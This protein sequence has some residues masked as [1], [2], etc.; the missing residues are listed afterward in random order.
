MPEDQID[1]LP[2][3]LGDAQALADWL[4]AARERCIDTARADARSGLSAA[5]ALS[6]AADKLTAAAAGELLP[7][8]GGWVLLVLGEW[9]GGQLSPESP[10]RAAL[11][12]PESE[13]GEL[14]GMAMRLFALLGP[15][16]ITGEV[17]ALEKVVARLGSERRAVAELLPSRPI[18]GTGE[19]VS[20][21]QQKLSSAVKACGRQL[22]DDAVAALLKRHEAEGGSVCRLEPD[23]VRNP[24][25]SADF[26][27]VHWIEDVL[28]VAGL[29]EYRSGRGLLEEEDFEDLRAA[30]SFLSGCRIVLHGLAGEA[31]ERLDRSHQ[32]RLAAALA[33][34]SGEE[35]DAAGLLMRDVLREMR[36]VYRIVKVV[37]AQYEETRG[38]GSK[39]KAVDRRRP[40]GTD[41]IRIGKRIYLSRPDL[42][43]GRGAG[44][45]M[46]RGF[47]KA[48]GARLE[49]SQEF[50]KRV[51]DNL[52]MVGD[53]VRESEEAARLFREIL[54]VRGA[55]ADVLR[56]MHESGFL[57]AYLPEF[58]EVDCLVTGESNQE[59]T[60]DEH[61]LM[62]V[63]TLEQA[64][65]AGLPGFQ[66]S[67]E[68]AAGLPMDLLKLAALVHAI[69]KSRG[70]SGFASRSAVMVPRIARQ[71]RLDEREARML[72][73][74][75]EH[76]ML[77]EDVAG[78]RMTTDE[79]LLSELV[80]TIGE[81]E[82][83]DGLY[84][85][86][87]ADLAAL[88]PSGAPTLR[89]EQ[90]AALY[91]RLSAR[92]A[93]RPARSRGRLAEEVTALLGDVASLEE[94]EAHLEQ[95]PE[96]YLLEV[97][98]RDCLLHLELLREVVAGRVAVD[99]SRRK[100][101]VHVWVLG[102]DRPRRISQI[103]GAVLCAGASIVSARAYTRSDGI[104]I[105]QFDLVP[106]GDSADEGPDAFW[107][108]AAETIRE[109]LTSEDELGGRSRLA[110]LL[111]GALAAASSE[112]RVPGSGLKDQEA[113]IQAP[114][115][116]SGT[117]NSEPRVSFDNLI[118]A[119]Y[120]VLDV[121][122]PDRPGL[123]YALS[124]G[125]AD[126]GADIAFAKINTIGGV[127][128]DVFYVTIGDAKVAGREDQRRIRSAINAELRKLI[129]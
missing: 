5:G 12:A 43:E 105:D 129:G 82:Y 14:T 73:F 7:A 128:Q 30:S 25:G 8:G 65:V 70:A 18:G 34:R 60:V 17:W 107:G 63:A 24:G 23:L 62:T 29:V 104:I 109:V 89:G 32:V 112:F 118:S 66:Q 67:T 76:Q 13:I 95:V 69:G 36:A 47:H 101:H 117:Q 64:E 59:Y 42:F 58:S 75:T 111:E 96:R 71:L 98:P 124:A 51:S 27:A 41:F 19:A 22:V 93:A 119:D 108:S 57:G 38:W 114:N 10:M 74:L 80:E 20:A 88:S 125:I 53:E 91:K 121:Q 106:A 28:E 102:P 94:L 92:L 1:S 86:S 56:A 40:L 55:A 54:A 31:A 113:G 21:W 52:Y 35:S 77:L 4:E 100:G 46:M 79:K 39:R 97:S 110:V 87:L 72:V 68:L 9:G 123:L 6:A 2:A 44:L 3:D 122:C 45:R 78:S 120:S 127:A 61:T 49:F 48:A 116:K 83:L 103:S 26:R 81:S 33:Y 99:W 15:A 126:A 50:L 85:S 115:P 37:V 16:G 11:L 84:L 90:L